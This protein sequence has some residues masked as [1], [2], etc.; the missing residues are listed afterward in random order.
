MQINFMYT[1]IHA[2]T[3]CT[4]KTNLGSCG[5]TEMTKT[6][7]TTHSGHDSLPMAGRRKVTSAMA[8]S[9]EVS[10]PLKPTCLLTSRPASQEKLAS[11]SEVWRPLL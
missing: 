5:G 7:Q 3:T 6:V 2:H 9:P 8:L 10:L 11:T 1:C 4:N